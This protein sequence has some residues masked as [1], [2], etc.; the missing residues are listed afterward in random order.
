MN[1]LFGTPSQIR[2]VQGETETDSRG[3]VE[4]DGEASVIAY[5]FT[6]HRC[7]PLF[8]SLAHS[9]ERERTRE[10]ALPHL[11]VMNMSLCG[12]SLDCFLPSCVISGTGYAGASCPASYDVSA[13][14]TI[15]QFPAIA[16]A[17]R[18]QAE[19]VIYASLLTFVYFVRSLKTPFATMPPDSGRLFPNVHANST[20][21]RCT[22]ASDGLLQDPEHLRGGYKRLLS[23]VSSAPGPMLYSM[24]TDVFCVIPSASI[25]P[26]AFAYTRSSFQ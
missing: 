8:A 17:F 26:V 15:T 20:A 12:I 7:E 24:I 6:V 10:S 21:R 11:V 13:S 9:P 16:D 23:I 2:G 3:P 22:V 18:Y 4:T 14:V 1:Q 19:V 5:S 25:L